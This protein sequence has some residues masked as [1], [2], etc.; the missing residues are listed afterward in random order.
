MV[1]KTVIRPIRTSSA[2]L[3]C[4]RLLDNRPFVYNPVYTVKKIIPGTEES[5]HLPE[6][7]LASQIYLHSL[8]TDGEP[9]N[10]KQKVDSARTGS[11]FFNGKNRAHFTI[12][13]L[14]LAQPGQQ[15]GHGETIRACVNAAGSD[16]GVNF[17]FSYKRWL[18][19]TSRGGWLSFHDNLSS[20][21]RCLSSSLVVFY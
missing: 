2:W 7:L 13:T 15:L 11:F 6:L 16:K 14:W 19:S 18:N 1:S 21:K 10:E 3:F 4:R 9:F 17:F 8:K 5:L 20:F 12:W